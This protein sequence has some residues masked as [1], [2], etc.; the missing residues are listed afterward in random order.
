MKAKGSNMGF[1]DLLLGRRKVKKDFFNQINQLIDWKPI[2]NIIEKAYD[3]GHATVGRLPYNGLMLFKIE[4]LRTW[5]NLSDGEVEEQVND[6]ISFSRFVG[7]SLEDEVPDSTTVCRFRN[8]MVRSG[9]YESLLNEINRQL[10]EEGI[11][12]RTGAIVDASITESPRRPH[13]PPEWEIVEDRREEVTGQNLFSGLKTVI[14][15]KPQRGV[16]TEARW[17]KKAG[18]YFY[19]YKQHDASEQ[20]HGLV[21]AVET[22]PANES[23]VK[24]LETPVR[25]ARLP[26][27]A[28]VEADKGYP[29]VKNAAFLAANK[30]RNHIMHKAVKNRALTK[31]EQA[32]NK[33]ISHTRYRIERTFGSMKRWFGAGVARYVG[34][35]RTHGQHLIEA[36]AYNLYRAPGIAASIPQK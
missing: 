25:K 6:R 4:L 5:Y 21:L 2:A 9:A 33:A 26:K 18:E 34:L 10:E 11:L 7:I 32:L 16:D 29:S 31:R 30:L 3:K 28:S 19:G 14:E 20:A 23:D 15:E 17:L 35:A 22:T 27:R 13:R 12:V 24:H 36:I 8:T 1:A